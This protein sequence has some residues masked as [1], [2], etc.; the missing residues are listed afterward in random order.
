[1]NWTVKQT[2]NVAHFIFEFHEVSLFMYSHS[3]VGIDRSTLTVLFAN[4]KQKD[5]SF[6]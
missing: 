6:L 1:M 3:F 5:K 4:C 2:V